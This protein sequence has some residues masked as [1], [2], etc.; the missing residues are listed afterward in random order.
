MHQTYMY[1]QYLGIQMI[2]KPLKTSPEFTRAGVYGQRCQLGGGG[3]GA[4]A[5]PPPNEKIGGGGQ[6]YHFVPSIIL[7]T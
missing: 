5:P 7:T 6:T 3:Q 4:V 1:Q 2:F